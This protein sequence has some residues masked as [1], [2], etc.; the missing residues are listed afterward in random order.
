[1]RY[2]GY[3]AAK[4][5]AAGLVLGILL[6]VVLVHMAVPAR[7][8]GTVIVS[9]PP[10]MAQRMEQAQKEDNRSS[11]ELMSEALRQYL[12]H[13]SH[14]GAPTGIQIEETQP[15]LVP[16]PAAR[17]AQPTPPSSDN[18]DL[19]RLLA[20]LDD[21]GVRVFGSLAL[22]GWF[23]LGVVALFFIV[24]DQ[25]YRC[26]VCLR[27]LRMPVETGSWGRMLQWGRPR[28]EYIC[29]YGH[30]TLRADEV[31]ISGLNNPEWTPQS[32]DIW[33]ELCGTIVKDD[34]RK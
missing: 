26:R 7:H 21:G 23:V 2:W 4:L 22:M 14:A 3:L 25:Q 18:K 19:R 24:R 5:A 12:D 31:Q 15:P 8:P 17:L 33:E 34:D 6:Y 30:G 16:N 28:V 13:R 9:L 27:R 11:S 20:P 10:A 29:P 1:M 32:G